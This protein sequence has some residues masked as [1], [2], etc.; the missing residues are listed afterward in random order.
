MLDGLY[1]SVICFYMAYLLFNPDNFVTSNGL[2][3]NDRERFGVYIAPAAIV[4]INVYIL[5]N[6]Y[7][8]DW[9]MVLLVVISFL[10]VWF[11]TGVYSSFTSSDYFYKAAAQ[12][13]GQA[14][15]WAVTTLAVIVSLLPRFC[16][17]VAQKVYFPYDVDIVREQVR[18]GKFDYLKVADGSDAMSKG[19]STT[20]SDIV[21]PS[22]HTHYPSVDEDQRPIY[23][24]SV[25]PTATTHAPRSQNGSDGTDFTRHRS[26]L[27]PPMTRPSMDRARPSY[28]R[29]RASM[30][31][32]RPSFEQ[33]NDFT[34]AAMLTR[35]ESSHSFGPIRSRRQDFR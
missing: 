20:S 19:S 6:T 15:F 13:F 35:M 3:T 22:K 9:L 10:L 25:A 28:D 17:K 32:I 26:S 23:P 16:I 8:W 12:T 1:Q 18:Q 11:W 34:S 24:P 5:L 2:N 7:R 31:R 14:T 4:C 27:D 30:D 21:K 33:S 29:M